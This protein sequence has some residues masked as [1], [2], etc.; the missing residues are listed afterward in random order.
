MTY[1]GADVDVKSC[2]PIFNRGKILPDFK[3]RSRLPLNKRAEQ[4][5]LAGEV[6]IKGSD[7]DACF[8][9]DRVGVE[10][11]EAV[12]FQNASSSLNDD[13]HGVGRTLLTRR[14]SWLC[15]L[16]CT[17]LFRHGN[18]ST[19]YEQKLIFSF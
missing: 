3:Q 18:A 19:P 2:F 10:S 4:R 8:L 16:G 13:G 9:S 14:F 12:P 7:T 11:F 1:R 17:S 6:L 15:S 5:V